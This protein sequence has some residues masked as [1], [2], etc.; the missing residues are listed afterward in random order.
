M[1]WCVF[2]VIEEMDRSDCQYTDNKMERQQRNTVSNTK[3]QT[4]LIRSSPYSP[5]LRVR[6]SLQWWPCL[7]VSLSREI[8]IQGLNVSSPEAGFAWQGGS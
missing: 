4:I 7:I 1:C 8:R 2:C 5:R 6:S 3:A